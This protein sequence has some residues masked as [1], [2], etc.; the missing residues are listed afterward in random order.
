MLFLWYSQILRKATNPRD[1]VKVSPY[2]Q[3]YFKV[4]CLCVCECVLRWLLYFNIC[5]LEKEKTVKCVTFI[6]AILQ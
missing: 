5:V 2:M 6:H 3:L 1:S 4:V